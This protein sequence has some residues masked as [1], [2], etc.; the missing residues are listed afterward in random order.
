MTDNVAPDRK[1][2]LRDDLH[3]QC[4]VNKRDAVKFRDSEHCALSG[5]DPD[6]ATFTAWLML[7]AAG[8]C[9]I[10]SNLALAAAYRVLGEPKRE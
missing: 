10:L 1:S 7:R 9:L 6:L 8:T 4:A 5:R 3:K 2:K